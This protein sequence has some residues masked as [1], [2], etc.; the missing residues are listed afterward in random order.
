MAVRGI[1]RRARSSRRWLPSWAAWN[2]I[3]RACVSRRDYLRGETPAAFRYLQSLDVGRS[4]AAADAFTISPSAS[5]RMNDHDDMLGTVKR[6]EPGVSAIA[7][8]P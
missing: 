7:L 6:P 5:R 4:E 2:A 1:S 3:R 8:A